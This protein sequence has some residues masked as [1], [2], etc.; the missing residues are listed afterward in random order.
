MCGKSCVVGRWQ[1]ESSEDDEVSEV[2]SSEALSD[3]LDRVRV[4]ILSSER[5]A[6]ELAEAAAEASLISI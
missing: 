5:S 6:V 4:P 2:E 3:E 1:V